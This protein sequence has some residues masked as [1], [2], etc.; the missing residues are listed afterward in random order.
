M[1]VVPIMVRELL[2][3]ASPFNDKLPFNDVS[4]IVISLP[5]IVALLPTTNSPP[6]DV[7]FA[8]DMLP[9]TERSFNNDTLPLK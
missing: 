2:N 9:F 4:F 3:T 8:D 7:F 1:A 6:I 5:F